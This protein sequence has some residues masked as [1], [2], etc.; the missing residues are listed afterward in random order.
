MTGFA[1][2][3]CPTDFSEPAR[4]ALAWAAEFARS[5]G[6]TIDVVHVCALHEAGPAEAEAEMATAVPAEY[7]DVVLGKRVVRALSAELGILNEARSGKA[8]LIVMGTHGRSNLKHVLL[9][10]VAERVV[11][12]SH[13][14]VLTVRPAGHTFERP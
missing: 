8:D 10:S 2:I 5:F 11:Q 6:G 1:R 12:L 3:L 7:D 13:C 9:G 4:E 14:P